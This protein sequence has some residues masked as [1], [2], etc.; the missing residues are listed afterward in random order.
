MLPRKF[1]PAFYLDELLASPY[2]RPRTAPMIISLALR[3][4]LRMGFLILSPAIEYSLFDAGRKVDVS[5][6]IGGSSIET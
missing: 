2:A 1:I 6:Q 5:Y 3:R 4:A